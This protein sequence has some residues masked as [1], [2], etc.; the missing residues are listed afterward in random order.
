MKLT[1]SQG[2]CFS[3]S[4]LKWSQLFLTPQFLGSECE[5]SW[6]PFCHPHFFPLA[7]KIS[8]PLRVMS[9]DPAF[10]LRNFKSSLLFLYPAPCTTLL[11]YLQFS[12]NRPYLKILDLRER[13]NKRARGFPRERMNPGCS[14]FL[15]ST[16]HP[17]FLCSLLVV[18]TINQW[19]GQVLVDLCVY[20][21]KIQEHCSRILI[22]ITHL[23]PKVH[24]SSSPLTCDI[25]FQLLAIQLPFQ[26]FRWMS[27]VWVQICVYSLLNLVPFQ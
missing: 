24:L 27:H 15:L 7:Y 13:E 8:D 6:C 3:T 23:T 2:H 5:W 11:P 25:C 14:L 26:H 10:F 19:V 21:I 18:L 17:P 12:A 22:T 1:S 16:C 4:P 20:L 9:C